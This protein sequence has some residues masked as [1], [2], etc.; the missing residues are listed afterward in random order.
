MHSGSCVDKT[1]QLAL[2]LSSFAGYSGHSDA[3]TMPL[4]ACHALEVAGKLCLRVNSVSSYME[5]H[6]MVRGWGLGLA[7]DVSPTCTQLSQ[8]TGYF[9]TNPQMFQ[10][11]KVNVDFFV[12]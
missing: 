10:R 6:K 11:S 12:V 4:L 3:L 7:T 1:E 5:A 8:H 9:Q 2:R